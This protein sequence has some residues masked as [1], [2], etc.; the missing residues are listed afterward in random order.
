VAELNLQSERTRKPPGITGAAD[1]RDRTKRLAPAR[2]ETQE[3]EARH[4][5]EAAERALHAEAVAAIERD[6]E[7]LRVRLDEK[8]TK[9][10]D[11]LQADLRERERRIEE[12]R[13]LV[14]RLM[15][16][17]STLRNQLAQIDEYLAAIDRDAARSRKEEEVRFRRP[18]AAHAGRGRIVR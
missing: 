14:L 8:K 13:Q 5:R 17:S 3:L 1:R 7:A 4:E 2:A 10:R 16:E 12:T 15:G 6:S 18:G 11:A 9:E